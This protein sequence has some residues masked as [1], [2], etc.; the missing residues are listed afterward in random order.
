MSFHVD[1]VAEPVWLD[2]HDPLPNVCCSCGMYTDHR[3]KVKSIRLVE[4]AG[5]AQA[6]CGML[7][8]TLLIH[9]ALGPLGW[10]ISIL[11][12]SGEDTRNNTKSVKV[13]TRLKI[14]QCLLCAG[15][16]PPEVIDTRFQPTQML[17]AVHP[18]FSRRLDEEKRKYQAAN[19]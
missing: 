3:V 12:H 8:I 18:Q 16:G 10:L 15:T 7:L 5:A 17:F 1:A 11:M 19:Q 4:Q 14:S 6:G 13:K 9:L 2:A